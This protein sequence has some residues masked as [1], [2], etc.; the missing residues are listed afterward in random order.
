[1]RMAT[2]GATR[3][4]GYIV[5]HRVTAMS[6]T[7]ATYHGLCEEFGADDTARRERLTFL[8]LAGG[9]HALAAEL[10]ATVIAPHVG[11]VIDRFYERL[12]RDPVARTFID[13]EETLRRLKTTQRSYLLSL[14]IG[15][16]TVNYFEERYRVG[17]A[18]AW[19]GLPLTTYQCAYHALQQIIIDLITQTAPPD[20]HAPLIAALLKFTALD[21]SLAIETYHG[22]QVKGLNRS[23][24]RLRHRE[25]ALRL[26]ASFDTLTE[27]LNRGEILQL[28]E[29]ELHRSRRHDEPLAIIM[30]DL[31][32]FKK[33]NDEHGHP[34]GD[35]V[36]HQ[37]AAR[38]TAAVRNVDTVGRYGGE[39]FLVVLPGATDAIA[40]S[41]GER[42][43]RHVCASPINAERLLVTMTV[44]EGV[45]V[46]GP[47]DTPETM[48]ARA[49]AALYRA[50]HGGRNRIVSGAP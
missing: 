13:D 3:Y 21:M 47:N 1:M 34:T 38:I 37:V 10:T 5:N 11:A 50:K 4:S 24:D 28:L 29:R 22:L 44:S 49:D 19:V 17:Q 8:G 2:A 18:H 15:F 14:G 20:R 16:D 46:A 43:R 30:I 41:V 45:T 31:D 42:I 35:R 36:L 40:M 26:R 12:Q 27:T 6:P 48:M 9:D 7:P 25:H 23:L 39:E 32:L 33:V